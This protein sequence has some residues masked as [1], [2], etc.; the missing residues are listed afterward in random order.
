[1]IHAAAAVAILAVCSVPE[2]ASMNLHRHGSAQTTL[3]APDPP[4]SLRRGGLGRSAAFAGLSSTP[5]GLGWCGGITALGWGGASEKNPSLGRRCPRVRGGGRAAAGVRMQEQPVQ[6]ISELPKL[7][8]PASRL[9]MNLRTD[10]GFLVSDLTSR[11]RRNWAKE[12]LTSFSSRILARVS[13]RLTITMAWASYV[14]AVITAGDFIAPAEWGS[15]TQ[16]EVP[17]WPHELIGGFLAILLVFRTNQSYERYWE[18]R[19]QWASL[20]SEC[21]SM[22][23]IA[24]TNL[25]SREMSSQVVAL[26]A[27]FPVALK[28]HLRGERNSAE[29]KALYF[30]YRPGSD[31]DLIERL[32]R[33][34]SIPS[35]VLL[36]LAQTVSPL[37]RSKREHNMLWGE[38]TSNLDSLSMIVSECEK[39]R[40]TPL[41]LSYSRHSSR[42]FSLFTLS[43][44]FALVKE[45]SPLLVP[46]VVVA[47]SWILFA[48][49]EIGKIIEDPFGYGFLE[50]PHAQD[51]LVSGG[52]SP[53]VLKKKDPA[54]PFLQNQI[55][56]KGVSEAFDEI[57]QNNDGVISADELEQWL[58]SITTTGAPPDSSRL[59]ARL[60]LNGDEVID[61]EEFRLLWCLIIGGPCLRDTEV[62]PLQKLTDTL[63]REIFFLHVSMREN[64]DQED[65]GPDPFLDAFRK[66][67]KSNSPALRDDAASRE[68]GSALLPLGDDEDDENLLFDFDDS[69]DDSD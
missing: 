50:V 49:D 56:L 19:K 10:D 1:M 28:Q 15:L 30:L 55:V 47:T 51:S 27:I 4:R 31:T 18:G 52:R 36:Q 32:C 69:M 24:L 9:I 41:P 5:V 44:P 39:L 2:A 20:T 26:L 42:F 57:D 61:F 43:L 68:S 45:T 23:R 65:Y 60:D 53:K 58:P 37:R 40:C 33:S 64:Q 59:M 12:L 8:F 62:L 35:S 29:I 7:K 25:E 11:S 16:F 66:Y 48:T 6:G 46:T 22:A 38:F 34:K 3:K 67:Y 14:T 54:A 17:G 13:F 21:R 63:T